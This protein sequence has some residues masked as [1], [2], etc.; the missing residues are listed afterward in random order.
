MYMSTGALDG[1][2]SAQS[3]RGLAGSLTGRGKEWPF[4]AGA[5]RRQLRWGSSRAAE[6][7]AKFWGTR[8]R[9]RPPAL[10]RKKGGSQAETGADRGVLG[11][12]HSQ[13]DAWRGLRSSCFNLYLLVL[14]QDLF[15]VSGYAVHVAF[16]GGAR[17]AALM[18][19]ATD[20]FGRR[21]TCWTA[22]LPNFPV[23][24]LAVGKFPMV[25][26]AGQHGLVLVT[27]VELV[28]WFF[29]V[30]VLS[31]SEGSSPALATLQ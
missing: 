7:R 16:T 25:W 11:W 17:A 2:S 26:P 18:G 6:K 28:C 5:A 10:R 12:H 15:C 14:A 3:S 8:W 24:S 23:L 19:I 31:H 29:Q 9:V 1:P 13:R 22:A 4:K 27:G 20:R 21:L 30:G